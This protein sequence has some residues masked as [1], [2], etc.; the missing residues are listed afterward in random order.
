MVKRVN[1]EDKF[2]C[3]L[4]SVFCDRIYTG[5]ASSGLQ[6]LGVYDDNNDINYFYYLQPILFSF[7]SLYQYCRL[8]NININHIITEDEKCTIFNLIITLDILNIELG[9]Q[10]LLS[11]IRKCTTLK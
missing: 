3:R 5:R 6:Y 9:K 7:Y 2:K 11:K 1:M 10:I 8:K 4:L